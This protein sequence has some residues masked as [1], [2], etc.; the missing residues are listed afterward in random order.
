[1]Y[2]RTNHVQ[3]TDA[4]S[5]LNYCSD[6]QACVGTETGTDLQWNMTGGLDLLFGY[7]SGD[8]MLSFSVFG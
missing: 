7:D 3:H 1:M 4:V 6:I 5:L 2:E 8:Y